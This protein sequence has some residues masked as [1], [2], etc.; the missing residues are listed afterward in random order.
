MLKMTDWLT[1]S[2]MR[3]LISYVH[4]LFFLLIFFVH[5]WHFRFICWVSQSVTIDFTVNRDITV[6]N[7]IEIDRGHN[8]EIASYFFIFSKANTAADCD[9]VL[10][11]VCAKSF[12]LTTGTILFN[13]CQF[14]FFLRFWNSYRGKHIS[15][16]WLSLL[17]WSV[18]RFFRQVIMIE[19]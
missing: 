11:E 9:C 17:W 5:H 16:Y 6:D 14:F 8:I 2:F 15:V 7:E 12:F 19:I 3:Y 13:S 1:D 18:N 10:I 4:F